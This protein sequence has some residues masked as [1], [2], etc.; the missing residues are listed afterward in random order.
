M[1]TSGH[2]IQDRYRVIGPLG[3]GGFGA[4]YL[5]TDQRLGRQVAIKEMS[6]TGLGP[7]ERQI[8]TDLFEREALILAQLDH[9]GLTRVWDFFQEDGRAFLLME[10]VPGLTLR[11]LLRRCGGPL[12]EPFV[13]ECALQLCAV[14]SY[15]HARQPPIIFR[16][17]KPANVMATLPQGD[18]PDDLLGRPL[19]ELTFKLID[20]GI[21]RLFKPEQP[22]DTLII[23][24]PGY[25]PPEQYGQGQTDARSDIYSLGATLHHM[26]SG[27]AP[28]GMPLPPLGALAPAVSPELGRVVARATLLDPAGRYP[29][30]EAMRRDLLAITRTQSSRPA[31][32]VQSQYGGPSVAAPSAAAPKITVPLAPATAPAR[33]QSGSRAP[34]LLIIA[35]ILVAVT[36]GALMLG[37]VNRQPG[38]Q[39]PPAGPPA[40]PTAVPQGEWVLPDAPGRI[41]FGQASASGG[42]DLF[43]ATLDGGA[44]RPLIGGGDD[45]AAAWS[46][47][48]QQVAITHASDQRLAVFA[49]SPANPLTTQ[50]SPAEGEARYPAWSPDGRRLAFAYRNDGSWRLA[51]ANLDSGQVR[52]LGPEQVAWISWGRGPLL[53]AAPAG[54]GMPQDIYALDTS[55]TPRNLTSS[56]DAEE[57]FPNRSPDSR[58]IAFVSSPP[59]RAGLDQRQIFVIGA[60]GSG[61]TQLTQGPGPH[62][63]PVW[64]PD[65]AWIAYLS[66]AAGGDWQVWAMHADGSAPQQ[67]TF[68]PEQKFYL[69][70]GK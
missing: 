4:V 64:S 26:L 68:G 56:S 27:H 38:R 13:V 42:Y 6:E 21:A 57:D 5:A 44:A 20:F 17:L 55:G 37:A 50:I 29:D 46:P 63:N 19:D 31:K 1:I 62:T 14:L 24:T 2:L 30:A 8:A 22:G 54:P 28:A 60:D 3:S 51:I 43:V 66:K 10:Y 7:H 18:D 40:Q 61:R 45:I 34:L 49:G 11:D 16:D 58:Q 35:G 9:P 36:L 23:G 33:P 15:L 39:A 25:A 53:Y 41:A 47:D 65:G 12:P 70:W 32:A 67:L 69:A 59:G 52:L 48:G